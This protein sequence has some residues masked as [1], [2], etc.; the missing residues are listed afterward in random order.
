LALIGDS[1]ANTTIGNRAR[2]AAGSAVINWVTPGPHV[3]DATA[4]LP[5]AML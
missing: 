4:I 5:V 2:T 1:P 3:T